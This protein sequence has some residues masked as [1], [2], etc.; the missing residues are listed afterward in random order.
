MSSAAVT[1]PARPARA[2]RGYVAA[3]RCPT[4]AGRAV[5]VAPLLDADGEIVFDGDD[6][7]ETLVECDD[8]DGRGWSKPVAGPS[9][10]ERLAR[11]VAEHAEFVAEFGPSPLCGTVRCRCPR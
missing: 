11:L 2:P 8:C 4:C 1:L 6:E 7:V 10:A 3:D 9:S 5:Q